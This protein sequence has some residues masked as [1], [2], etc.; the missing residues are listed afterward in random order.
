MLGGRDTDGAALAD[1]GQR[2][3]SRRRALD[4]TL[5]ELSDR[6]GTSVPFLSQVENGVG[7]PSLTTLFSLARVLGT[8]PEVLLAGPA[9]DEV[10]LVRRDEG[11]R[12]FVTDE[13]NSAERRQITG[14]D[15]VFSASEYVVAPGD[16]LGGFFSSQ[17]REVLHVLTGRLAVDLRTGDAIVTHELDTGDSL[18]Y[19]TITEHRWRPLG[20][21]VTRFLHV[22]SPA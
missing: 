22:V 1:L 4:L 2:I 19:S 17:G 14:A 3:R 12:Y 13:P 6:S 20:R 5:R 7:T 11:P 8:S 21:S 10:A 18:V 16:D 9:R 15:E